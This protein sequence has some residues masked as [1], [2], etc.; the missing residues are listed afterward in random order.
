LNN[1]TVVS[2][3]FL[4]GNEARIIT[5]SGNRSSHSAVASKFHKLQLSKNPSLDDVE[6]FKQALTSYYLDN[7]INKIIL[8]R[9]ATSGLGTGG[10]MSFIMEGIIL[11]ISNIPIEFSHPATVKATDR[12]EFKN[13]TIKPN[14]IALGKAYDLAYEGLVN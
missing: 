13:K 10:A 4:K 11:A 1:N 9:R 12:K 5:L 3:V 7:S 8:N 6:I 2:G 14:T